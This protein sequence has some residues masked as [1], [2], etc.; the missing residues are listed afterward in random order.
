[1]VREGKLLNLL[2]CLQSLEKQGKFLAD[3]SL[4]PS[5]CNKI[6]PKKH[7]QYDF[8]TICYEIL[9]IA[10]TVDFTGFLVCFSMLKKN[11][12][13][14]IFFA[15]LY[16]Q[17]RYRNPYFSRRTAKKNFFRGIPKIV[18]FQRWADSVP[19]FPNK[20]FCG[21]FGPWSSPWAVITRARGA[22]SDQSISFN[23][24]HTSS[25][26]GDSHKNEVY[27]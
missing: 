27:P 17:A 22:R 10:Q 2:N 26:V 25:A 8:V 16:R 12:L 14:R 15:Q 11:F 20:I 3:Q 1:M 18:I 5:F 7:E 21:T 13:G 19:G 24:F 23:K 6:S 4:N 9:T